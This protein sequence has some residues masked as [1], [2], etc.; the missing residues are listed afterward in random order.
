M[1]KYGPIIKDLFNDGK[2]QLVKN[3]LKLLKEV[4]IAANTINI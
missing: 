3:I 2:T 1:Q 4:F